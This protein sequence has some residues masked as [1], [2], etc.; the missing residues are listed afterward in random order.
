MHDQPPTPPTHPAEHT[1]SG[2]DYERA[3]RPR[4][5]IY[6]ASLADYNNGR[7]HGEW[8]D[9]ARD[10]SDIHADIAAML[11]RSKEPDAEEFAIHDFEQFGSCRIHEYDSI[12]LV[13]RLAI[14]IREHGGAFAA[15]ADLVGSENATETGFT[16]TYHGTYPTFRD[17][18]DE[19][20]QSLGWDDELE[21]FG[22]QTG[23]RPFITFDYAT[24][25]ATLRS[26][27][28]VVDGGDEVHIFSS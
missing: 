14:G 8:L 17:F 12:E 28:S 11:A 4:P 9:A 19:F 10:P 20:K 22:D 15:Y 26:E 6:V 27:W 16:D 1:E 23:L 2:A 3:P 25:E 5:S 18:A 21:R 7:L 13:S 24:F